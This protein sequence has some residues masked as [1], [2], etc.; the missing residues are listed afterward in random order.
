MSEIKAKTTKTIKSGYATI[1]FAEAG[2]SPTAIKEIRHT[3][4]EA[5]GIVFDLA[6]GNEAI[7]PI[8]AKAVS[9]PTAGDS[10]DES[11]GIKAASL[12]AEEKA[13][14]RL[15]RELYDAL[16]LLEKAKDEVERLRYQC[17]KREYEINEER[18]KL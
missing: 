12:K 8:T 11:K 1:A 18:R 2:A 9:R 3:I 14:R 16:A 10:Y 17:A 6:W 4:D 7:N 5:Y 15:G 13:L